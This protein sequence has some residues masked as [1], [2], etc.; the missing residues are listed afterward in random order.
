M[1]KLGVALWFLLALW[2]APALADNTVG[3]SNQVICNKWTQI[4]TSSAT[5]TSLI[6]AVTTGGFQNLGQTIYICGWHVTTSSATAGSFQLE[7]GTQG[8]P[9]TTPT[10]VT[11]A[12]SVSTTAPSADHIS[13]ATIV[14]PPGVQLCALTSATTSIQIEIWYS[15]F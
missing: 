13:I 1:R 15:Q 14:T 12:F 4:T 3:P 8:G 2:A 7:Y 5:T 11:P 10:V 9:C 6:A